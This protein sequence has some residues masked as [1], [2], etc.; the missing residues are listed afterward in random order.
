MTL[1][2]VISVSPSSGYFDTLSCIN[3][4]S[5][6][7]GVARPFSFAVKET[8]H[9]F[10][11]FSRLKPGDVRVDVSE[12]AAQGVKCLKPEYIADYL[13]QVRD[14]SMFF[15]DFFPLNICFTV[16]VYRAAQFGRNCISI[17]LQNNN[18]NK[19]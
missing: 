9:L 2:A 4:L 13:M 6:C 15:G 19:N 17:W 12:A 11:D 10:V 7:I 1:Q 5:P 3:P 8:T 16:L 14:D 18:Y